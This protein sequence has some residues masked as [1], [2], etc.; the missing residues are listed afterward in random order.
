MHPPEKTRERSEESFCAAEPCVWGRSHRIILE[1]SLLLLFS[2][3]HQVGLRSFAVAYN[4]KDSNWH[5]ISR[6]W[7]ANYPHR[8][9]RKDSHVQDP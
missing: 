5:F 4:H 7:A 9:Y 3:P 1:R 2:S 6:K 8:A